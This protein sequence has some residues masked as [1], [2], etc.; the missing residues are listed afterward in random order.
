MNSQS[1]YLDWASD[2]RPSMPVAPSDS[3]LVQMGGFAFTA[4][5]IAHDLSEDEA[6]ELAVPPFAPPMMT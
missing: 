1:Q 6:E 5:G 3:R 4:M 2:T